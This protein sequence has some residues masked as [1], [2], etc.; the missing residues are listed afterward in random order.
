MTDQ[1]QATDEAPEKPKTRSQLEKELK[2]PLTK[3]ELR[4]LPR[5]LNDTKKGAPRPSSTK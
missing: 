1:T 5:S 4:F 2:R 3:S